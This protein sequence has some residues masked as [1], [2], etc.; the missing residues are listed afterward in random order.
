MRVSP[1]FLERAKP[2]HMERLTSL[3]PFPSLQIVKAGERDTYAVIDKDENRNRPLQLRKPS[4]KA[5][6]AVKPVPGDHPAKPK[7]QEAR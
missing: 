5:K 7:D 4:V 6:L 2:R 3:L 1:I